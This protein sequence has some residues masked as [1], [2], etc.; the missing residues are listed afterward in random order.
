[1]LNAICITC[2]VQYAATEDYPAH[3]PICEDDRQ[4]VNT[5]GQQWTTLE[6]LQRSH[7]NTL[8]EEE[9]GL[10]GIVTE[11]K[12]AIG[13]RAL[14]VQTPEGNI[15]WDCISLID[16]PTVR[17]INALGGVKAIAI[18]H[19]HLYGS[20]VDWSRAL[21]DAP[22]YLHAT[23]REWVMRPD[24]AIH[25]WEEDTLALGGGVTLIRCG[26]HFPGS[27]VLHWAD[28]AEGRGVLLTADSIMVVSD[29]KRVS[30]MY[31]YP[32][33]L[34]LPAHEV[35]GVV[36]AVAPFTYDR[37]YSGWFD[38]TLVSGAKTAVEQS[39]ALYIRK[40]SEQA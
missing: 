10:L 24:P 34:P 5:R 31:S 11:P 25:F 38:S 18:S 6:H 15:L 26:G 4:Y 17:M 29:R 7:R 35:Q 19:P 27:T 33:M 21:G 22:I 32:N 14:L 28:G 20:M 39:A 8:K 36:N 23:N 12:F 1:M 9:P 2:G 30:F 3:C 13:Q 16:E 40:V 37:I